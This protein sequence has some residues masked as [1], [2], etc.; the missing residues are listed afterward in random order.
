M[1]AVLV[2]GDSGQGHGGCPQECGHGMPGGMRHIE[3][4]IFFPWHELLNVDV[5]LLE[6]SLCSGPEGVVMGFVE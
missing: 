4:V 1:G 2:Y 6:I 3:W 5:A